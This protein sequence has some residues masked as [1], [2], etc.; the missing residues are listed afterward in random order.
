MHAE[1]TSKTTDQ[2]SVYGELS[3][4]ISDQL[5]LTLGLRRFDYERGR[6]DLTNGAFGDRDVTK[7][8][9]ETG[10]TGKVNV[11]YRP[12]DDKLFYLQWAEGFRLGDNTFPISKPLCDVDD[13]DIFDGTTSKLT[14][15]FDSDSV[16]N[17]ELGAKLSL[18]DNRVQVNMSVYQVDWNDIP[19]QIFAGKLPSQTT[20]TCFQALTANA[21]EAQSKGFEL[22]AVMQVTE[23]LKVNF[24]GAYTDAELTSVRDGVPFDKVTDFQAPQITTS[25][26]VSSMTFWL[27]HIPHISSQIM[28]L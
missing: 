19:L 20:Q 1:L 11:S 28:H 18:A 9:D 13:N 24:G 22:E 21:G 4:D 2:L 5:E 14:S 7:Q 3:Y 10:T 27:A 25:I 12:D 23:N 26:S 17:F 15:S 6:R 16:E 8:F